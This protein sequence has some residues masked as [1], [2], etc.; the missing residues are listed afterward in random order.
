MAEAKEQMNWLS[1]HLVAKMETI[2]RDS[3]ASIT[4]HKEAGHQRQGQVEI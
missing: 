4:V 1:T 3:V 2:T